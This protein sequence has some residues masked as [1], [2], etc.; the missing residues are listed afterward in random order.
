MKKEELLMEGGMALPKQTEF[1]WQI[2]AQIF[3]MNGQKEQQQNDAQV[4]QNDSIMYKVQI[5]KNNL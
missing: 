2:L 4:K 3:D 1:K 5:H